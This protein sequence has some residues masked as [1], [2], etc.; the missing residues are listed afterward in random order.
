[1]STP[2]AT[3]SEPRWSHEP[4]DETL[5]G[6]RRLSVSVADRMVRAGW[7]PLAEVAGIPL[8]RWRRYHPL[9]SGSPLIALVDGRP[10]FDAAAWDRFAS[11]VPGA[12]SLPSRTADSLGVARDALRPPGR[13]PLRIVDLARARRARARRRRAERTLDA[14]HARHVAAVSETVASALAPG[15]EGSSLA[16]LPTYALAARLELLLAAPA[17]W[18]FPA[19]VDLAAADATA[20]L[21]RLLG[22]RGLAPGMA[23]LRVAGLMSGGGV[24]MPPHLDELA[25]IDDEPADARAALH[26]AWIDG[27]PGWHASRDL[28]LEAPPLRDDLE[29]ARRVAAASR[30]SAP[31]VGDETVPGDD[32]LPNHDPALRDMAIRARRLTS[33]RELVAR[34]RAAH[35]AGIRAIAWTLARSLHASSTLEAADDAF[36]LDIVE[37]LKLARGGDVDARMIDDRSDARSVEQDIKQHTMAA[38]L[39]GIPASRGRASGRV[40]VLEDPALDADVDGAVLFCRVTDPA[41]LPLMVRCAGLVTERGG[42]L[43]HAAIVAREIG[44]PAIV[45]AT[46]ARAA[47]RHAATASVDGATGIV[48]F[49][50][51]R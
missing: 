41:W 32:E 50:T 48:T 27:A 1:M 9:A 49:D 26:A 36:D 3:P 16:T 21:L 22:E 30:G 29:T 5:D 47:A 42:P 25:A 51:A 43:S 33:M 15:K 45:G 6:A 31:A 35:V 4:L 17:D 23:F 37:L 8:R 2:A 44:L 40:L 11:L 20:G 7:E 28:L 34:D 46:G 39:R 18:E 19:F 38:E 24:A 14:A 12:V 10:A 13:V